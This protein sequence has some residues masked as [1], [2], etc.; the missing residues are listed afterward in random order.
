MNARL[1]KTRI[2]FWGTS[3]ATSYV[4]LDA[5]IVREDLFAKPDKSVSPSS[6]T[7]SIKVQDLLEGSF[8][9]Q[10]LRKPD[11]QRETSNWEPEKVVDL[12]ES[13]LKG[14]FVPSIILWYSDDGKTF[15]IDGAH[16]LSA[17]IAWVH[18][19]YG[20]RGRSKKFFNDF[21]PPEQQKIADRTRELMKA[22]GSY[23][24]IKD[25][26]AFPEQSGA[27]ALK[28]ARN[29][30]AV[31]FHIQWVEGDPETAETSFKK[32]N[33]KATL[34]D[35]TEFQ[36]IESRRKAN[37]I[38]ARAL[39]RAGAGHKYWGGKIPNSSQKE[40]EK[41]A[42]EIYDTLFVPA[43][44]SPIKTLDLPVA[45]RGYSGES[46]KL[47]FDFINLSNGLVLAQKKLK[48]LSD[49][50]DGSQTIN[51]LKTSQRIIDRI[52]SKEPCSLGLH[53]AVYFYSA[54]GRYQPTAF[55]AT[56][57]MMMDFEAQDKFAWFTKH[58]AKFEEFLATHRHFINQIVSQFGSGI[59]GY[60]WVYKLHTEILSNL[61]TGTES[62]LVTQLINSHKWRLKD[63][64]STGTAFSTE[65][66]SAIY[67]KTAL[68]SAIK[69]GVCG[70]R[71]H[72]NSMSAGHIERREDGGISH[73]DN[74][75][76]EHFYCN[77]GYKEK[78]ASLAKSKDSGLPPQ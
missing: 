41:I 14:D 47:I 73:S 40:I 16:R 74:G 50:T 42:K 62:E 4:N 33:Q 2:G 17:L 8:T 5:L 70:A 34:I 19:D 26:S 20:D 10:S 13:F 75:Q 61:E 1:K 60:E 15:V 52:C 67:L 39:I 53:P 49:D 46:V 7:K 21:I 38:A 63:L 72:K 48:P 30:G 64:P 58:R 18:D 66:K 59:K 44:E 65:T 57:Q 25:A 27:K 29:A 71:M 45:G 11:F 24:E 54:A 31:D 43:L 69:C 51:F 28:L 22:V 36:M 32:I 55:L 9:F 23:A 37:A 6:K 76:M 12:V 68:S 78:L 56:V 77:T 35:P 3:M